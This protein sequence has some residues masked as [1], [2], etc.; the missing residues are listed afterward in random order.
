M[1]TGKEARTKE[2]QN[3]IIKQVSAIT[4][5][6]KLGKIYSETVGC[7]LCP[8]QFQC[9]KHHCSQNIDRYIRKGREW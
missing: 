3:I 2:I 6:S 9:D 1:T 4:S 7:V 8:I 5:E